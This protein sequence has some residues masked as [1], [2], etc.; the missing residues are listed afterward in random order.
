MALYLALGVIFALRLWE[1]GSGSDA[2]LAGLCIGLAAWTKNNALVA[3]LSLIVWFAW[4]L[5]QRRASWR[6]LLL[7]LI[8]CA[9]V[10]AP[11][12][13]RNLAEVGA[14]LPDTAWVDQ[15]RRTPGSLLTFVTAPGSFGVPGWAMLA[16]IGWAVWQI[17]PITRQ[18]LLKINGRQEWRPYNG[19]VGTPFLA[20]AT[21]DEDTTNTGHYSLAFL[22]WIVPFFAAWWLLASYETRFLVSLLPLTCALGGEACVAGWSR[23]PQEARRIAAP[24]LAV[25]AL[26][27]TLYSAYFVVEYKDELL[28]N[29]LMTHEQK[30]GIV[31]ERRF[32]R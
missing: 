32:N 4:V 6:E 27:L 2:A 21:D 17:R 9:A 8:A 18:K 19:A 16:G 5:L 13:L 15:A 24:T 25:V 29:P 10:S 26:S 22:L 3:I 1:S 30:M 23:L 14:L 7:G 28:R 20:S 12:Y 31:D 11:W